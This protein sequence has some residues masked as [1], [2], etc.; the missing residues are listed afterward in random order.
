M[1]A[2]AAVQDLVN[3]ELTDDQFGALVSFTFNLGKGNLSRSTLLR[4]LNLGSYDAA[5]QQFYRWTRAR[6]V[7]LKGLVARRNCEAFKFRGEFTRL[8]MTE[9]NREICEEEGLGAAPGILADD[10]DILV[11]E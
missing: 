3:V 10:I 7:I 4:V 9:F 6:G 8:G 1:Q 11:G 2:R 5:E